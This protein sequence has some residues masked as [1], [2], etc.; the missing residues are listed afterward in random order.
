MNE[1]LSVV[2]ETEIL[3]KKVNLY[4]SIEDPLFEANEV[5]KWLD[6]KK[7]KPNDKTSRYR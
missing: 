1:V 7:C 3:G 2:Q 4:R 6:V 5:A